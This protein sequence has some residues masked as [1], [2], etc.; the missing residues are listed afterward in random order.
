[1]Q[2]LTGPRSPEAFWS[3][4]YADDRLADL[5]AEI[6]RPPLAG[7][8]WI[9]VVSDH[10]FLP[11]RRT[12]QPNSVLRRLGLV[13][14]S[15]GKVVRRSA[16]C[17]SQGGS[18]AVYVL[19]KDRKEETAARLEGALAAVE[20]VEVAIPA[21]R[22]AGLGQPIPA[23]DPRA[24]DLWLSARSGYAF[25]EAADAP[26]DVAEKDPPGGTHGHLPDSPDLNALLVAWGP[27]IGPGTDLG[28]VDI[29]DIAPT[30]ARILGVELPGAEGRAL[31][32]VA[33]R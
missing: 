14:V 31:E 16:W 13:E 4:S 26:L 23:D 5:L 7:K 18:A 29:R 2:H 11:V 1:M 25:G 9:L 21:S 10:G 15:E 28:T 33:G 20:G 32:P 24:P 6:A 30:V 22:F 8:T 12:I 27:G 17:I 19:Q 3:V